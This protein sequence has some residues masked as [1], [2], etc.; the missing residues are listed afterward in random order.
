MTQEDQPRSTADVIAELD[1]EAKSHRGTMLLVSFDGTTMTI[2]ADDPNRLQ[3]LKEFVQ[4]GGEPMGFVYFD[5]DGSIAARLI[6][7]HA[8][9]EG[10]HEYLKRYMK[11]LAE[12]VKNLPRNWP[13]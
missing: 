8:A 6:R 11:T 4:Q 3:V 13:S 9:D 2:S 7:E 10:A 5:E 12:S 1:E